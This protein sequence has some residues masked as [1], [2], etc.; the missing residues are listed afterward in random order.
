[1]KCPECETL[2]DREEVD[3]GV[4]L[5]CSPWGCSNCGWS[6]D[7]GFPMLETDWNSKFAEEDLALRKETTP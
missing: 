5:V 4:G 7:D 2:C 1:M 3:V 6:E